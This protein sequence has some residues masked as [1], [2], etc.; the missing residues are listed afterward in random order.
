MLGLRAAAIYA[1][2]GPRPGVGPG[3]VTGRAAGQPG[4]GP[5]APAGTSGITKAV[6]NRSSEAL[7]NLQLGKMISIK[8]R[9]VL[10]SL[11]AHIRITIVPNCQCTYGTYQYSV[12][13]VFLADQTATEVWGYGMAGVVLCISSTFSELSFFRSSEV[14]LHDRNFTL[15]RAPVVKYSFI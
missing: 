2:A 12:A 7:G 4:A 14:E 11:T 1:P 9:T 13:S 3:V 8:I 15:E 6:I 10:L 5:A